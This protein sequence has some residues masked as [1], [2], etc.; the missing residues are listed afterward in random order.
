MGAITSSVRPFKKE[1]QVNQ[2]SHDTITV[3]N[4]FNITLDR[5][6]DLNAFTHTN[7]TLNAKNKVYMQSLSESITQYCEF[8]ANEAYAFN[9][10]SFVNKLNITEEYKDGKGMYTYCNKDRTLCFCCT[11]SF[12]TGKPSYVGFTGEKECVVSAFS[13]FIV[14]C[15]YGRIEWGVRIFI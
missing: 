13:L 14:E 2:I 3:L 5:F 6:N 1:V 8:G 12:K 7:L 9:F 10:S 4:H 11:H 15:A